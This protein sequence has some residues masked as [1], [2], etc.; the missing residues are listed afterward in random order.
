LPIRAFWR[1]IK[2]IGSIRLSRRNIFAGLGA[3]IT[4]LSGHLMSQERAYCEQD[5][6][7]H[8]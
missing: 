5:S 4:P 2:L 8:E 7:T 3:L 1:A 6:G